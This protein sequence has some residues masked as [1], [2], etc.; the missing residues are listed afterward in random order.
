MK[1][2]WHR[3]PTSICGL[4]TAILLRVFGD[5]NLLPQLQQKL[6]SDVQHE[7]EDLVA[8]CSL[9][10]LQ[11]FDRIAQLDSAFK[12]CK[13]SLLKGWLAEAMKKEGLKW[14]LRRLTVEAPELN[15]LEVRDRTLQWMG[16][17]T[18]RY[19]SGRVSATVKESSTIGS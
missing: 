4:A 14:E 1:G 10:M 9:R 18:G 7:G 15:L 16:G 3:C 6:Y 8:L 11:L 12:P 5:D 19:T 17:D 13:D 2:Q